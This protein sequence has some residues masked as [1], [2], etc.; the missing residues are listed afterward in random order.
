[1][2]YNVKFISKFEKELKR[3]AKKH[4]SLKSDFS[5]LLL[6][7]KE[8]PSQGISLGNDCYKI[9]MSISSKGKG[10]SGGARVITCFKIVQNTVFL[11]T[12]FDKSEQ[13]NIAD[14][15]LKELLK[16]ID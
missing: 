5:S 16:F 2:S 8:N 9:R 15:E 12:I 4:P 7:L 3:L 14:K 10:K 13:E 11:L 6:S 1:M